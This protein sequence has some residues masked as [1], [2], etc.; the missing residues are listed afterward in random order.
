MKITKIMINAPAYFTIR[1]TSVTD[2]MTLDNLA[3]SEDTSL[4]LD[5]NDN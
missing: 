5:D 3:A 1:A 4:E 2:S